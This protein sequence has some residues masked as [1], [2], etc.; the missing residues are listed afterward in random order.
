MEQRRERTNR[1][2]STIAELTI[3]LAVVTIVAS[4]VVSFTLLITNR[5]MISNCKLQMMEDSNIVTSALNYWLGYMEEKEVP[6]LASEGGLVATINE[7][8]CAIFI[9]DGLLVLNTPEK[10]L[11]YDLGTMDCMEIHMETKPDGDTIYFCMVY[12]LLHRTYGEDIPFELVLV[13]NP[14][15]GEV[16]GEVSHD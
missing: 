9:Q 5:S 11:R 2:G 13:V 12:Y 15:I 14:H 1:R 3:V 16:Y 7:E 8:T 4:L 10:N 6:V